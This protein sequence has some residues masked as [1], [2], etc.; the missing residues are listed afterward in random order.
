M[1]RLKQI[2]WAS[3]TAALLA[4]QLL[5]C[6]T[7]LKELTPSSSGTASESAKVGLYPIKV[8]P[9]GS[10]SP[11]LPPMTFQWDPVKEKFVLVPSAS[12]S[13]TAPVIPTVSQQQQQQTSYPITVIVPGGTAAQQQQQSGVTLVGF[14]PAQQ[15]APTGGC[16][17]LAGQDQGVLWCQLYGLSTFALSADGLN[18]TATMAS[19]MRAILV[20]SQV[21]QDLN[22]ANV[23]ATRINVW[24]RGIAYAGTFAGNVTSWA[25]ANILS[26]DRHS[27][28]YNLANNGQVWH[29]QLGARFLTSEI[30]NE[31][32]GQGGLRLR[33][34][35]VLTPDEPP[36][37][38]AY[39]QLLKEHGVDP[40]L[41]DS[42]VN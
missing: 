31:D 10:L 21:L 15:P 28:S 23:T 34:N 22:P 12:G 11:I 24:N 39:R 42:I 41:V 14:Q 9:D 13:I 37:L 19:P 18:Y 2:L 36:A 33:R 32:D 1:R 27:I 30:A 4:L 25:K 5:G 6:N 3:L 26:G 35:Y 29:I 8:N 20:G 17:L 40:R 7:N 16:S 38:R